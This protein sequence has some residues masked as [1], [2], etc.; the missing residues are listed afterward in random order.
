MEDAE[1]FAGPDGP[2]RDR[3]AT[4]ILGPPAA[5]KSTIAEELA[6]TSRSAILDSDEIKKTLPEYE[7]GIGAARV[8]EESSELTDRL[9]EALRASG[10]NII[11]P[12][13]GGNPKSIRK[14]IDRFKADGYSVRIVN[15]AV[16]GDE[17]Y[18]RMI[19]RFL[20]TG[21]LIPPAYVREVG[22]SPSAT[23]RTLKAEGK[24]DGYAEIDNNG[25]F[26]D[27]KPIS[28]VAGENP[29][30][31]S[32]YDLQGD[33]GEGIQPGRGD[34]FEDPGSVQGPLTEAT[35]AGDQLLMTGV[36]PITA[37]DRLRQ[38]A[39]AP[40]KA[41][42]RASDTEI[43]GLFD[44]N[45]PSRYDLFDLVPVGRTVDD[46]G[47]EIASTMTRE[48]LVAELDAEDEAIAVLDVCVTGATR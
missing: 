12:K 39:D 45:D 10:T 16:T 31:G 27:P 40:L 35:P 18:R 11:F 32:R 37:A 41:K 20:G 21:R 28:E 17:A 14:S 26:E 7:G 19:S 8:H 13:V 6:R 24:A 47:N 38:K 1:G 42:P 46:E 30:A 9:E 44:P 36:E 3:V 48:E 25:G 33:G 22:E 29:F 4:I 43:G 23:F 34:G 2:M 5:G 15:M